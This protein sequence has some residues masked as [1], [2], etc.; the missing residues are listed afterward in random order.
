MVQELEDDNRAAP[1]L[2]AM[3]GTSNIPSSP[4][5]KGTVAQPVMGPSI[6]QLSAITAALQALQTSMSTMLTD[7]TSSPDDAGTGG[8]EPLIGS[9]ALT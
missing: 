5:P 7:S 1:V 3:L 4:T 2:S 6:D 9:A 8:A